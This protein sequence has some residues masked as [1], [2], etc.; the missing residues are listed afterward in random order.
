MAKRQTQC[1]RVDDLNQLLQEAGIQYKIESFVGEGGM[2]CVYKARET[3]DATRPY[4]LK[5]IKEEY[6][7]RSR[8]MRVFQDEADTM[9]DLQYPYIVRFFKFVHTDNI[10]FILMDYVDG[11][12]LSAFLRYHRR[13][14]NTMPL[15]EVTRITV[16]VARAIRHIHQEKFI[17]SDIKPGNILLHRVDGHAYLSDLGIATNAEK[18]GVF[19]AAGT[20]PYMPC[21]QQKGRAPDITADIYAFAVVMFEML[22][23]TRPFSV[24]NSELSSDE[25]REA[26]IKL[27]CDE[28]VPPVTRYRGDLPPEIDAVF[29]KAL[30]KTP[31]QRY[32]DVLVFAQEF[33]RVLR[34]LL[35][36]DLQ[37]FGNIG[38]MPLQR[39]AEVDSQTIETNRNRSE[40]QERSSTPVIVVLSL[41][42]LALVGGMMIW[43]WTTIRQ[44]ANIIATETQLAMAQTEDA[45]IALA[46]TET[47][48]AL[49]VPT[50]TQVPTEVPP[51]EGVAVVTATPLPTA[52][53][54]TTSEPTLTLTPSPTETATPIPTAFL[55]DVPL[56]Y[57]L[58][59]DANSSE[60]LFGLPGPLRDVMTTVHRETNGLIPLRQPQSDG[61]RVELRTDG[62]LETPFGIAYH[63]QSLQ[64]FIVFRVNP[65][66]STWEIM[67]VESGVERSLVDGRLT[68][69]EESPT[70]I[71]VSGE[72]PYYRFEVNDLPLEQEM[73]LDS[74]GGVGL[75]FAPSA[76][77]PRIE[78]IQT[79]F[80]GEAAVRADQERPPLAQPL[81]QLQHVLLEDLQTL[82]GTGTVGGEIDCSP[83]ITTYIALDRYLAWEETRD[84][85]Q[86]A[87]NAGN[88]FYNRCEIEGAESTLNLVD[89]FNDY[90]A[91][92]GQMNDLIDQLA[93]N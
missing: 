73:T 27:H 84:I 21:E 23:N 72:S 57:Y 52:T 45:V 5:F 70:V 86:Q 82:I 80:I 33:H 66:D 24:N 65:V 40:V 61:F 28:P 9:R 67:A 89:N 19:F 38:P 14:G 43:Q 69:L 58:N 10:A 36:E 71:T 62:E 92:Q 64:D 37:D 48:D 2:A 12:P 74:V 91:W 59:N 88:G 55:S 83:Y 17:H 42:I 77:L 4:A 47:A 63:V 54:T 79:G 76:D 30:A 20:P 25:R 51:T 50:D 46:A 26:Y 53:P 32:Q 29:E 1:Q 56:L 75:W 60:E 7:Q 6:R 35:S 39:Q 68:A 11:H 15:D 87:I 78:F 16:Q 13:Q 44:T 81:F 3:H 18:S 85:A 34:P 93:Q 31:Q 41:V 22:T 90:L 8:L 49:I